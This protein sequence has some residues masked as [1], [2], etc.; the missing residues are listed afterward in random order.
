MEPSPWPEPYRSVLE[1]HG[2]AFRQW[3]A[4]SGH[5]SEVGEV[6]ACTYVTSVFAGEGEDPREG[7]TVTSVVIELTDS[8]LE[9]INQTRM[10]EFGVWGEQ[11]PVFFFNPLHAPSTNEWQSV[12]HHFEPMSGVD[13]EGVCRFCRLGVGHEMHKDSRES[14]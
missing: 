12:P 14:H 4:P 9:Q 13:G 1:E 2:A 3:G 6:E 11:L 7:Q 5:E 10:F 8:D